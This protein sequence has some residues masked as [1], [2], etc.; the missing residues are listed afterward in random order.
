MSSST[1]RMSQRKNYIVGE[2]ND[3]CSG[4]DDAEDPPRG[5]TENIM[6]LKI[7]GNKGKVKSPQRIRIVNF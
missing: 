6:H 2:T 3:G 1:R 4:G 7:L 5:E